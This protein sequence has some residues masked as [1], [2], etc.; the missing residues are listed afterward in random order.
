MTTS[1]K[2]ATLRKTRCRDSTMGILAVLVSLQ[3]LSVSCASIKTPANILQNTGANLSKNNP[4]TH[5]KVSV[6]H[7]SESGQVSNAM[8][9]PRIDP[10]SSTKAQVSPIGISASDQNKT[11]LDQPKTPPETTPDKQNTKPEPQKPTP[12]PQKAT[13]EPQKPTPEPQKPT[14][15]PQKPTP[16]PQ[17]PTPEPQ[18]PTPEPQKPTPEPQK[19]TPEPQ[20][21]T[22]EPQK[23]ES[24]PQK[25]EFEP[26]KPESEPQK[27]ESEP[28]KPES[29]P[30]KPES[31]PQKPKSEPQKPTPEPTVTP[32]NKPVSTPAVDKPEITLDYVAYST[33]PEPDLGFRETGDDDDGGD[34]GDENYDN[35]PSEKIDV[36]IKDTVIYTKDEDSHFFFHLVVI[37]FLVAIVYITYHNKRKLMLLAQSRRWRDGFCSRGVEYHRLDQNVN[38]AMPSLKMTSDYIF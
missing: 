14:P 16:E 19:A 7:G 29:E 30:Q 10:N 20:K 27:P 15:E 1:L 28:Q 33:S 35:L 12:E 5:H 38:E 2:M 9:A 25:P 32:A 21:P 23:P 22:P 3:I 8:A 6:S 18:K 26:Q 13:P 37:A 17:K 24:E 34:D 4:E 36:N 11:T 31:E